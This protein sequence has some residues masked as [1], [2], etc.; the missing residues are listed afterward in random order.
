MGAAALGTVLVAGVAGA[1][2]GVAAV[3]VSR[4]GAGPAVPGAGAK[5]GAAVGAASMMMKRQEAEKRT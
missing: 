3:P 1:R 2:T 5:D 4:V